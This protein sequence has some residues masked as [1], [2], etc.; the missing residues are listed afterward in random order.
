MNVFGLSPVCWRTRRWWLYVRE[1]AISRKTGYKIFGRYKE[2]GLEALT[3]RSRRPWRY[4][5][6]LPQQVETAIVNLKQEKP[7]WGARK[8]RERLLRR[9]SCEIKVP[10]RS[11]IH[12]VL[13]R[14]GLVRRRGPKR[15]RAHGT[16]LSLGQK[17]NELWCTDYKGEFLLGN[18]KYCYPLTVTDHASR[19]L[20]LCEALESTCEAL[21][22]TAFAR[23]FKE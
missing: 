23:L 10:A 17:P 6:Q 5:N 2:S 8:I 11:T 21:A 22:F 1:F 12:A 4:G 16:P 7:Y 13:D 3:D 9:F 20:L 14:H 15:N 18:K 19:Y